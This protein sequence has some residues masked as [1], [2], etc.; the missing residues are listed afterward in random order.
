MARQ[1]TRK[2]V[3]QKVPVQRPTPSTQDETEL[4]SEA[5][6]Q[7]DVEMEKDATE[8]ELE[9]LVFG[10]S[11]G[12]REG[13]RSFDLGDER[14]SGESSASGEE[15]TK[16]DELEGIQDD[17]LF[18]MD[19]G[20]TD[21]DGQALAQ[22]S[23]SDDED[24][25]HGRDPP[26][27]EDSDE[28]R[29]VVSLASVPRLRKLRRTE[30]EDVI[31]GRDYARRLRRQFQLLNP[32]PVWADKSARQSSRKRR[33]RTS[34]SSAEESS[35]ADDMETNDG[36]VEAQPLAKLLRDFDSLTRRTENGTSRKRKLRSEVIDIQRMKDVTGVQP[37]AITSLSFHPTLPLLL[38]SGPSSTLYLH[39]I[40]PQPPNPNP[41]L[42]S[43]HMKRTPLTTTA[44]HPQ[45]DR[46]FLSA[47][48]RYFHIWNLQS[49][50]VEKVSRVY[51][52]QHE[53]RSMERFKL[54]PHGKYLAL[55]GSSRKGGG[56]INILDAYTL[57]WTSQARIESRGGIAEFEW[58]GDG[59]GLC[60]AGKNGEV[61]EWNVEERST[62]ARWQ[63][64]G[65][66]GTAVLALGG[67]TGSTK[68]PIGEDRWVAVGSSSGVVNIYDRRIWVNSEASSSSDDSIIPKAPK[69]SR[70]FDQLT[71]PI[72]HLVFSP[73]GQILAMGSR[74]KK[75]ALRLV[76]LPSCS[77]YRNW[78]T[79]GTPLG[80]I[81]AVAFSK[82]SDLLAVA[83][84]QG[85][86]RMWEIR[87]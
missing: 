52:H 75:D 77:V 76:H 78:P 31:S 74:W 20:P 30:V 5:E 18:F 58:W 32:V 40:S 25:T 9:K 66:V 85:K 44:F 51:G 80:R 19:A 41:L 50:I 7:S 56:V 48:R 3:G 86:I 33:R 87:S 15:E 36:E 63:D 79:N 16:D 81:T 14:A 11:A 13:I 68:G 8:A 22:A 55:L 17:D 49:G 34:G 28:E 2:H 1:R 62:V 24:A 53:Q 37:S 12:F 38:S 39:H 46:I 4:A 59:R 35:S 57:Q 60:I 27:W 64:E 61:T 42:T 82:D 6:S 71:T 54:S 73:D 83:N 65:A 45:D 70:T 72:S 10:D 29:M 21:V 26:A 43:L 84:E 67:A 23:Q 47:R 69:P